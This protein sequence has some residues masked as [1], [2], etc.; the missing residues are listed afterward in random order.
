MRALILLNLQT[1][2]LPG[3]A[4]SLPGSESLVDLSNELLARFDLAAAVIDW[5]PADHVSFAANHP[6]R[7]PGQ[8]LLREEGDQLLWPMHCVQHS[9]G[10]ALAPRLDHT[11]ID[12]VF[13]KGTEREW[14]SHSGFWDDGR[15]KST[16]LLEFLRQHDVHE[17]YLAGMVTEYDVR[18][19]AL[20]ALSL[21]F[22]VKVIGK[23]CCG[24]DLRPGQAAEALEELRERGVGVD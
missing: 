1:D 12:Q 15:Q 3:G 22:E 23:A 5:H 13:H 9:F 19:T 17:L 14:D 11:A 18:Q 2:Y 21:G 10:A 7:K 16:G 24:M 8:L 20:D 4:L 6:W